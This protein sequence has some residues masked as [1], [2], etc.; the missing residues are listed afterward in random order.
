MEMSVF[1]INAFGMSPVQLK[2]SN[3]FFKRVGIEG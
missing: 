3:V 2:T 1:I